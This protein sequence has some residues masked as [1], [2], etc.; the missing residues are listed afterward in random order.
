[1]TTNA[2]HKSLEEEI[3]DMPLVDE[4]APEVLSDDEESVNNNNAAAAGAGNIHHEMS[5]ESMPS[6]GIGSPSGGG[7]SLNG[8]EEEGARDDLSEEEAEEKERLVQQI[9]ELQNTLDG[10][11]SFFTL[12]Q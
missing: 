12:D 4:D 9:M 8:H 6:S 1:M 11:C 10:K 5:I 2:G 7:Q 3:N